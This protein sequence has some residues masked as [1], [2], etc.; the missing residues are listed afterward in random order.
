MSGDGGHVL[1]PSQRGERSSLIF[2]HSSQQGHINA[3]EK[4]GSIYFFGQG[5]AIDYPRAMA[6]YKVGAEGGDAA[7]KHQILMRI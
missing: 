6:A 1:S 7:C 4:V 5:A 2:F 3:A